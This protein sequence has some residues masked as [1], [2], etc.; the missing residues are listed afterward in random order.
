M[1]RRLLKWIT[2][3]RFD[4]AARITART[5]SRFCKSCHQPKDDRRN[6]PVGMLRHQLQGSTLGIPMPRALWKLP[7]VAIREL[8]SRP[9]RSRVPEPMAM[10]EPDSVA[11]FHEGGAHVGGMLAVY[12]LSARALNALVPEGGGRLL[13][14]GVGA[15]RALHKFLALRP[16]VTATGVDL[17]PNML[18]TAR[19]FFD[20]EGLGDR[21][22]LVEADLTA[23]PDEVTREKWDA[24]SCVWTLHHLP[25]HD[26]LRA[27]LRQMADIRDANGCAVWILDFQRLRNP[28][29]FQSIVAVV[30]ADVSPV[31]RAD[32]VASE[33][34]AFTHDELRAELAAAGLSDLDSGV[35]RPIPF[36]Q[37]F[38]SRGPTASA[39]TSRRIHPERVRGPARIDAMIIRQFSRLPF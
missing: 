32:G 38:W 27:A 14:L 12:D 34:A 8:R 39:P 33:A 5:L 35:A 7:A 20:A 36:L 21:V 3:F 25:D 29:T 30:Q 10:D 17:A 19:R 28:E 26:V 18:A 16:D 22:S 6:T 4:E 9:G 23:L 31:P 13:D 37:A 2:S 15:G 24:V 11:E 1:V